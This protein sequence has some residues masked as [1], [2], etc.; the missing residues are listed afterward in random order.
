MTDKGKLRVILK[1]FIKHECA[2][3]QGDLIGGSNP[4]DQA[5]TTILKEY[6]KKSEIEVDEEKIA[7]II[8]E[9]DEHRKEPYS[10]NKDKPWEFVG[11]LTR[12]SYLLRAHAI[13]TK[14]KEWIK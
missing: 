13:A 7:Q 4:I 10:L 6:V 3:C 14:I 1:K 11:E 5:I 12:K 9:T 2:Y 8:Y